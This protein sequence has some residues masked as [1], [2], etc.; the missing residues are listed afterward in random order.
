MQSKLIII[1]LLSFFMFESGSL[2]AQNTE[3]KWW[4]ESVFYQIY[5]PSYADSNGDGYGDFKGMTVKLDYLQ[6]LGIKG[7]WLTPFLTS[8]KVD[9]GYDIA[10]Y[11]KVDP[12]YGNKSD[13]EVFLK[14]AHKRGIKVIMDMVLNHTSTDCK[15][16]QES[17]K[18]K[19]NP[20]RDYYIWKDKPNNWES[21]FGGTAWQKDTLTDQFYYHKFDVRMAD[22]NWA[23]PKV[24]AEVQK[25]LRFWLDAGVDGFRLDVIN[26]LNTDGIT[27]DNPMKEG[28]QDHKN[29]I[30]QKGVKDAMRIIKST[31][32]EYNNRFIVGEIGSDKIEVLKQYQSQ[33]LLDVVFNFNFGSIKTF[34]SKRIFD[35]LQSMEKNMSNYPTLFFGSHDMPRMI[36]R[37]ADGSPNRALALAALMLTAKG[38][39][40]VYYGEEIGMHN[41]IVKNLE[42]MVDIQGK[43]HYELTLAKGNNPDEA[44]KEGNEHNRD[45]SRS[46]M[47]WNGNAFAGFSKEKTWIKTNSDYQKN[48]VLELLTK[49]NSILNRYKKLIA[50]RNNE[51]VLQ[52]GKY[53]RLDYKEDQIL[54]T[55]SFE[56]DQITVLIN[57]GSEKKISLPKGGQ[58]LMG[59]TQL[60][61]NDF[62]IYR[63]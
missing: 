18:S 38:V 42:E 23:N 2:K 44:L 54:F 61:T 11:Y 39:P 48:N 60:K 43:T 31:V 62:I 1:V 7:I 36:D 35:E 52:Y 56:G 63:N 37:L 29:D 34:S 30:D 51:K 46:P 49:E 5:M 45:K 40:F 33:D 53:D 17:R 8:P 12:T 10:N 20:Y 59:S 25:V 4:K 32:N 47:Q 41:I 21:F 13:F 3:K 19:D 24:V 15:W 57:F 9:N 22:L 58:I 16:F 6:S 26:F 50:L 27:T 55:R 28:V 14:E